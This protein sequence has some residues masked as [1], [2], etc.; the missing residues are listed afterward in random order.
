[1]ITSIWKNTVSTTLIICDDAMG[2]KF[3]F[4]ILADGNSFVSVLNTEID[5]K[6]DKLFFRIYK[7]RKNVA[8]SKKTKR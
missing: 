5:M 2:S 1:M 4:I 3:S 6:S 8:K 7:G